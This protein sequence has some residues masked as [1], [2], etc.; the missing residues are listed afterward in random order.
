MFCI[1]EK[2][3]LHCNSCN[4][5]CWI[6]YHHQS[7]KHQNYSQNQTTI[8]MHCENMKVR[9]WDFYPTIPDLPPVKPCSTE[10][11]ISSSYVLQNTDVM[12]A[13]PDRHTDSIRRNIRL[14]LTLGKSPIIPQMKQNRHLAIPGW[15]RIW[16]CMIDRH[17]VISQK[18]C[19]K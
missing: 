13:T 7:W 11:T 5:F 1:H 6:S 8:I 12:E 3:Q 9:S 16:K 18:F 14:S 4:V 17:I 15:R 2:C 19:C 10:Y